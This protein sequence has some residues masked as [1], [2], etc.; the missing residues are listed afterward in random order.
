MATRRLDLSDVWWSKELLRVQRTMSSGTMELFT[1]DAIDDLH[2]VT[3]RIHNMVT[4]E[5]RRRM[6]VIVHEIPKLQG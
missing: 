6:G 2:S 1:D 5:Y 4:E 3:M